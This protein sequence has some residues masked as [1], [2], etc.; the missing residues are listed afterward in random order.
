M[1]QIKASLPDSESEIVSILKDIRSILT[2]PS[3]VTIQIASNLSKMKSVLVKKRVD[4]RL[5]LKKM[6]P[7]KSKTGEKK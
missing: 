4:P 6:F 5:F 2:T 1:K 3:N 7:F